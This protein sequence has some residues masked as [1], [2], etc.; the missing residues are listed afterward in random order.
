[1]SK[2]QARVTEGVGV[3]VE[4]WDDGTFF[5][6]DGSPVI[7]EYET[8]AEAQ[9]AADGAAEAARRFQDEDADEDVDEDEPVTCPGCGF[10]AKLLGT[11]GSVTHYRCI[12]CGMDFQA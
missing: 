12:A 4:A 8:E 9:A 10:C 6:D 3:V 7:G 11:L 2:F 5:P 1:M